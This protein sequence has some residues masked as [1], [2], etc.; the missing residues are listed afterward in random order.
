MKKI[1]LLLIMMLMLSSFIAASD[2]Y[3]WDGK[4]GQYSFLVNFDF[5]RIENCYSNIGFSQTPIIGDNTTPYENSLLIMKSEGLTTAEDA[6]VYSASTFLY[7]HIAQGSSQKLVLE[8][9]PTTKATEIDYSYTPFEDEKAKT[10]I[11]KSVVISESNL[12]QT[13]DI[14]SFTN[15]GRFSNSSP[16]N[17]TIITKGS[18]ERGVVAKLTLRLESI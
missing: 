10:K 7:W 6:L 15:Y 18:E 13:V 1:T 14:A 12:N 4:E 5:N 3:E 9:M 2:D 16:L 8:I 17:I 11:N